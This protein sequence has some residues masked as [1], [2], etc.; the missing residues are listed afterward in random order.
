MQVT[1]EVDRFGYILNAENGK[2]IRV[3]PDYDRLS[4]AE[5]FGWRGYNHNETDHVKIVEMISEASDYL[6]NMDGESIED[7]GWFD[8]DG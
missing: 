2:S 8:A 1:L 5:Y 4:V 6:D 3:E 7:P